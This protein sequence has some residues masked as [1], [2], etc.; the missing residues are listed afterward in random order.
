MKCRPEGSASGCTLPNSS[1]T[2]AM[3]GDTTTAMD[4]TAH[5]TAAA[6][7]TRWRMPSRSDMGKPTCFLARQAASPPTNRSTARKIMRGSGDLLNRLGVSSRSCHFNHS[8]L[9]LAPRQSTRPAPAPVRPS[10]NSGAPAWP[11]PAPWR[12]GGGRGPARGRASRADRPQRRTPAL[13]APPPG[14]GTAGRRA[15]GAAVPGCPGAVLEHQPRGL[16]L[17]GVVQ[18]PL[19]V[20]VEPGLQRGVGLHPDPLQAQA[21]PRRDPVRPQGEGQPGP[22]A[23]GPRPPPP[24]RAAAPDATRSASGCP[25][26]RLKR[27]CAAGLS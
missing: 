16:R 27:N 5:T 15:S 8:T 10:P 25:V 7:A 1:I 23:L 21:H 20:E 11:W 3:P 12:C 18:P 2:P 9:I 19:Q 24:G 4:T 22:G 26:S 13:P 6:Q 14:S 17:D